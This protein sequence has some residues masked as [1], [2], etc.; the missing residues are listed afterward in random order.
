MSI[1]NVV[2]VYNNKGGV[3]KTTMAVNLAACMASKNNRCLLIDMDSQ[4]CVAEMLFGDNEINYSVDS[5]GGLMPLERI[6][7]YHL[8]PADYTAVTS[9]K[10]YDRK[11]RSY[12]ELALDVLPCTIDLSDYSYG[13]EL[14]IKDLLSN[15]S[16]NYDYCFIDLPPSISPDVYVGLSACDYLIIPC[17]ADKY[18]AKALINVKKVIKKID[19]I[20]PDLRVIGAFINAFD[21]RDKSQRAI[22][23]ALLKNPFFFTSYVGQSTCF[24]KALLEGKP[25]ICHSSTNGAKECMAVTNEMLKRIE[26][27]NAYKRIEGED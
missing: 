27:Y 16:G 9:F 10:Y 12:S 25:V 11:T 26:R 23:S 17:K 13:S 18:A 19:H 3:G 2:G 14:E 20:N 7:E 22:K 4:G 21:T 15:S 24:S 8:D 5:K 6:L 1:Q